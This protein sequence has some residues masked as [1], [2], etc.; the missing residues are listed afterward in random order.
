MIPS[1]NVSVASNAVEGLAERLGGRDPFEVQEE[2]LPSLRAA[3]ATLDE[4]ALRTPEGSDKWSIL[5]AVQHLADAELA[6][7]FRLRMIVAQET[8][9]LQAFDQDLWARELR[10]RDKR[11]DHALEQLSA[12][13]AANLRTFRSLDESQLDRVGIHS[14]V[15]PISARMILYTLAVHDLTHRRQIERI[16]QSIGVR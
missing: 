8:P 1:Q 14:E 5:E 16:K 7:G 9:P 10:Y 2:L 13:R 12:L 6:Y 11:L 3:T 15:G 4:V